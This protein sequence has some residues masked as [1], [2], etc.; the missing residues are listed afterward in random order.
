MAEAQQT[1]TQGFEAVEL[2]SFHRATRFLRSILNIDELLHAIL[3]EALDAVHG[4]RG[5]VGLINRS[6]GE[7]ELRITAGR[8]WAEQPSRRLPITDKPGHGITIQVAATGV[9]Y[10]TGDVRRDPNY[11]MFFPD[12]RSEIAVPLVNRDGRTIGVLNIESEEIDAFSHQDLQL[13]MALASQASIANSMAN[14]RAREAML[15]D[16]GNELAISGDMDELLRCVVDRAAQLLRA[17]DCAIFQLDPGGDRLILRASGEWLK[18]RIGTLTYRVGEGLTGWVTQHRKPVRIADVRHDP[19]W[20]GLY[21]LHDEEVVESYMAIPIFQRGEIWGVLRAVRRRPAASIITNEFTERDEVLL[22]TLARQ[23]GAAISQQ[24]LMDQQ[25]QMER[26]AAW[27][28][29]SARSAHMIGNKVFAIKGQLNELEWLASQSGFNAADV[30]TVVG[31]AR[32]SVFQ[33]EEILAEFRDFLMA[34]HLDRTPLDLNELVGSTACENGCRCAGVLIRTELEPGLPAVSADAGKLRRALG[35]LIENAVNHQP[36]G[37]EILVRTGAWGAAERESY[38]QV[39]FL[40]A[41]ARE[42]GAVRIE[43]IDRGPGV[44]EVHKHRLFMPFFTTRSKGMGLGLSIVK[45]IIDAHQG[46]IVEAGRE[47]EGAHFIVVLPAL[48]R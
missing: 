27:G 37:G 46:A 33:L 21:P 42:G 32:S 17:D 47:G 8:G 19:R 18:D 41:W 3:E 44:P 39:P 24:M 30:V 34:T 48:G 10:V 6:T 26:M 31:R 25:V 23:V 38:P 5:F 13:L 43:V 4:T 12:V 7:L 14:Y 45:G 36:E 9:P 22:N 16:I 28:E 15:I 29:M 35:E 11:V 40:Q 20:K 2:E 1:R